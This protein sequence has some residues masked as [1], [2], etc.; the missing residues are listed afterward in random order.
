[1]WRRRVLHFFA[2]SDSFLWP[3]RLRPCCPR[4]D[5]M[6]LMPG[7]RLRMICHRFALP[8]PVFRGS[9]GPNR[10]K[11]S[12]QQLRRPL[13]IHTPLVLA[14]TVYFW[15]M[16]CI[17]I[18]NRMHLLNRASICMGGEVYFAY[19]VFGCCFS[20]ESSGW[21]RGGSGRPCMNASI[22]VPR[23]GAWSASHP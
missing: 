6:D 20:L 12:L 15:C 14:N 13:H 22:A 16:E 3:H 1:M 7:S 4:K 5:R 8:L 11:L 18:S 21:W 2:L 17:W 9:K 23:G 10:K 19:R